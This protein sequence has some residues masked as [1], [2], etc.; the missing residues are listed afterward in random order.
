MAN[1][2]KDS[3]VKKVIFIT[4]SNIG[5]AV[6]TLPSLDYLK[7]RFKQ[8]QF[9]VLSG[10]GASVLF[11]SDPRIKENIAY[12]KHAPLGKK[13]YLFNRLRKEKFDV[14]ID[15][16][17]TVFRW[18]TPAPYKN[19]YIIRLPK[20]VRHL[21]L[22]HLYKT[23]AAF[24]DKLDV[25][26]IESIR[27]SLC[28][29]NVAKDKT[30]SLL[31]AHNLSLDSDYVVVSAGS[32]SPAKRWHK[33]GFAKICDELL[34][35]Y[36]VILLGDDNDCAVNQ[37]IN[38]QLNGRCVDLTRKT[39]LSEA[40]TVLSK[41][42]LVICNDS[43]ISHISS[44]LNRPTLVIFGPTD[45]NKY[46]PWS[47]NCAVARKNT[48]C[49][50]CEGDNC[51][52]NWLCMKNIPLRSVIDYA[53]A[54]L[55]GETPKPISDY[56]RIL[57]SRTD[58]LGDVLLSTPV[59]K[60]LRENFPAA[61]I[62][63]MI[64]SSLEELLRGNP[65]LD[66]VILLDKRGKHRGIVNSFR[67]AGKLKKKNFDLVLILHPTVRVHI[68]LF[69]AAIKKR[70]G[71]DVKWGFL[72]THILKHTK[73]LGQKHE[74]EYTLEFL[75]ELGVAGFDRNMFM[76]VY[77]ESEEWA[78]FFLKEHNADGNKV[79][80]IHAQASCPSRLWPQDYYNR[81]VEDIIDI[82]KAKIIYVGIIKDKNIK[83][84]ENIIN[85]TGRTSISQ[86]ASMIK[87]SDLLISNDS[88]PVHIAVALGRPVISIFGRNQP[89]LSP[90]RWAHSNINSVFV[91][92]SV[93]CDVCL[94]HDCKKEYAC[95][96]AIEPKEILSYVDEFLSNEDTTYGAK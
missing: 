24:K 32:R 66:E 55:R 90:K 19:P 39:D 63:M 96:K 71:Y 6:L 45:E 52:N 69:L 78:E 11:A 33:E 74:T 60:N 76:P 29:D 42:K 43:A 13:I 95:L 62:A 9:T 47:K 30:Q 5:D 49:T 14:I 67:F 28:I 12:D 57:V 21:R 54:L 58:R 51:K 88:G 94:A 53:N 56:R 65:Y 68:L 82:Y 41:A 23:K 7:E 26:D 91:H 50:P 18:I 75:R 61:Y 59:I 85:M 64:K 15:L 46:G 36:S 92:K 86:L 25:K 3:E 93:G 84:S 31:K 73:Q 17:D 34:K 35:H 8:A 89:G 4:L 80:L 70:I 22:R 2:R 20:D 44:Y 83:E 10:P 77:R 87:H 81:L 79:V 72:N 16:R 37:D 38:S 1:R 48:F 27:S 40:I